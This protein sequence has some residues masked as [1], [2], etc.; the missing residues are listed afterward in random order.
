[1]IQ[2]PAG[3]KAGRRERARP[4]FHAHGRRGDRNGNGLRNYDDIDPFVLALSDPAAYQAA[5]PNC[6][7][8]NGDCNGDGLV[9]FA[10][11]DPF[12]AL[13]SGG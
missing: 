3:E 7:I 9:N 13:L 2:R 10:D 8:L 11:I 12:V 5:F 4:G 1:L 6:N